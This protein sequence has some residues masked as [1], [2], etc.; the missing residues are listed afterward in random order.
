MPSGQN[1]PGPTSP[2]SQPLS[3][4]EH[5]GPPIILYSAP[6][7]LKFE[8]EQ[9][10]EEQDED[11]TLSSPGSDDSEDEY[12][13]EKPPS[14]SE[15]PIA[16]SNTLSGE[17][18]PQHTSFLVLPHP[19]NLPPVLDDRAHW[20]LRRRV[21]LT[22][23]PYLLQRLDTPAFW[24]FL[25]LNFNVGLTLLNK[26]VLQSFPYPWTLAG[27][28]SLGGIL[29]SG[30]AKHYGRFEPVQLSTREN[31]VMVIFSTLYTINIGVSNMSLQQVSIPLH[32]CTRSLIPFITIALSVSFYKKRPSFQT[33][34]S[35]FPVVT[36]VLFATFGEYEC[37]VEGLLL[38]F[39]GTF[40][41]ALKCILTNRVQVGR[42]K[43]HPLDL[44]Y[45]MSPMSLC[46]CLMWG[47]VTGESD[48]VRVWASTNMTSVKV[49]ALV[50]NGSLALGLNLVSFTTNKKVDAST[51]TIA[52]NLKQVLTILLAVFIFSIDLNN[53]RLFGIVLTL[54][55]G[56]WFAKIQLAEEVRARSSNL[57]TVVIRSV[58]VMQKVL[59]T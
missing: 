57:P 35:L 44:L 54:A 28:H 41:A 37:R 38:T 22:T 1:H 24:L 42:L 17:A 49:A 50:L 23:P 30:V 20:S 19:Q 55:G 36:G 7:H 34:L 46:Q 4:P 16:T 14:D 45:Q 12:V 5:I 2:S 11:F 6:I 18:E 40:L 33:L 31:I 47:W 21:E 56:A 10:G 58:D 9:Q 52:A 25:Y 29:G 32:Q 51:M 26:F 13:S 3:P 27:I 39:F 8:D 53:K 43:L 48:R 59:I 15:E